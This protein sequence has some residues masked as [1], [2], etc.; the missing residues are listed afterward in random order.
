MYLDIFLGAGEHNRKT[1]ALLKP[2][3]SRW[4][5]RPQTLISK[6]EGVCDVTS[7]MGKMKLGRRREC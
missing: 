1:L 6:I 4:G 5:D 2:S 3:F 7:S